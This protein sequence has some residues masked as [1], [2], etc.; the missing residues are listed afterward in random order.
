MVQMNRPQPQVAIISSHCAP[1]PYT[2]KLS[3]IISDIISQDDSGANHSKESQ[4]Y[5]YFSVQNIFSQSKRW[6]PIWVCIF[7]NTSI[8]CNQSCSED[9]LK[10]LGEGRWYLIHDFLASLGVN[11]RPIYM[12]LCSLLV[13]GG[14][15]DTGS[16]PSVVDD[17]YRFQA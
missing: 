16:R 1:Q 6:F 8:E 5:K 11:D 14:P 17:W 7:L 13:W 12:T 2:N 4:C 15:L 3:T 9:S 10:I